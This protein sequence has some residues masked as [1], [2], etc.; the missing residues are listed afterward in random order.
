MIVDLIE[1]SLSGRSHDTV[2]FNCFRTVFLK[3][4]FFGS[5]LN[6][7]WFLILFSCSDDHGFRFPSDN[8]LGFAC[9]PYV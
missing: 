3:I 6:D 2:I 5:N 9:L 7:S 4:S 8:V 1:Q